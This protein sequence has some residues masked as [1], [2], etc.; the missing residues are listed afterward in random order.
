MQ[1]YSSIP[2]ILLTSV[3]LNVK[4]QFNNTGKLFKIIHQ[5]E[6]N[7]KNKLPVFFRN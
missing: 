3:I 7:N 2:K 6:K 5:E 4:K 1:K